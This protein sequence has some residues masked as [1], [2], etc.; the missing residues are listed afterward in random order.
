MKNLLTFAVVLM[1]FNLACTLFLMFCFSED[2]E[3]VKGEL[4]RQI[5]EEYQAVNDGLSRQIACQL[6]DSDMCETLIQ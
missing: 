6:G 5:S 2:L 4:K 3:K 1:A